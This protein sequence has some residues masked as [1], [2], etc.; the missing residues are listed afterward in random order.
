MNAAHLE[1]LI[2]LIY[3]WRLGLLLGCV[4]LIGAAWWFDPVPKVDA[5]SAETTAV[6]MTFSEAE[7]VRGADV[8]LLRLTLRTESE[9]FSSSGY[10]LEVRNALLLVGPEATPHWLFKGH[11]N[12][13]RRLQQLS[14]DPDD[15]EEGDT[16]ALYVEY[17]STDT[18]GDQRL[19]ASDRFN[20]AVAAPD[21]TNFQP[22]LSDVQQVFSH[23][24]TEEDELTV[25]YQKADAVRQAR[26]SLP[27]GK[28]L[29]DKEVVKVPQA[30]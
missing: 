19:S 5:P 17:V 9:K 14:G 2:A 30:L 4:L 26:F 11:Q 23:V 16:T 6:V 20:V 18:N 22:L 13:V 29:T 7:P 28:P 12:W 3:R 1:S 10:G 8:Q 27:S 25:V 15:P 24:V 21:G